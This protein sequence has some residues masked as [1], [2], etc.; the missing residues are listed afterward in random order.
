M[1]RELNSDLPGL[2]AYLNGKSSY[3]E[4]LTPADAISLPVAATL[5]VLKEKLG[6][7]VFEKALDPAFTQPSPLEHLNDGSW[8]RTANMVGINVRTIGHFWNLVNYLFTVPACQQAIHLLP[9]WEPG[10]VASLYGM[11]SWHIN[12]EFFCQELSEA[13]PR[14]DTVE[15]QLKVTVNLLHALGRVVGMDVIPHTDRYSE[16]VLANPS[17][18]EWL[19]RKGAA[20]TSHSDQLFK[21]AEVLIYQQLTELGPALPDGV[22]PASAR[23]LFNL[24]E[25]ARCLLLFGEIK[26]DFAR[27]QRRSLFIQSLHEQGLEPV[28]ATMGPP[29]RGLEVDIDE[30]DAKIIEEDTW[31]DYRIINPG[32]MSRVFGPLTRYK[33]Y[34]NKNDNLDWEVDFEHPTVEVWEYVCR[35]YA[36]VQQNFYFDFMRGDMSH[37]QMRA[38][39]VPEVAD[40]YYDIHRAVLHAIRQ[41]TP[42]FGYFAE[43][44]LAPPGSMAY[45]SEEDHLDLSE[46]D[47][48]LGDL[49]SMVL[50]EAEFLQNFRLYLDLLHTRGFAP[51]FTLMTGDKDDPRFDKF[52]LSGNEA[53]LFMGLFLTDMPSYMGLGFECRDPHPEPAPNEHYTKLYVFRMEEGPKATQGAYVFGSNLSLFQRVTR[54]RNQAERLLP[55]ITRAIAWLT[56]PDATGSRPII[57]WTQQENSSHIFVVN[58]NVHAPAQQ[59]KIPVYAAPGTQFMVIFSAL[60]HELEYIEPLHCHNGLLQIP[61]LAASDALIIE[62]RNK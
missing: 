18:F 36:A 44:F 12:R 8:M 25:P 23:E 49:Q 54:I 35:Q 61:H 60:E 40:D 46:A 30:E 27:N 6:S 13:L 19:E 14:L 43:T 47:A 56:P 10:V 21:R 26:D 4:G 48:T 28:P 39:G 50:G 3:I 1:S 58:A 17:Y 62:L 32:P 2:A 52:Y 34:A 9:I 7:E 45:G 16:I 20:I 55:M 57:A 33:L 42:W 53:R 59:V 41:Y 5:N 38:A 15:K 37:V 24:P 29:Y 11:A 22:L 51:C 31:L